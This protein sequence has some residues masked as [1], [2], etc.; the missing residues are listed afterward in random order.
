MQLIEHIEVGSG[1][2]ASITFSAIPDTFTDLLIFGS[3]RTTE[4]G[5]ID[6]L[7]VRPN[8]LTTNFSWRRLI[9]TG[10]AASSANGTSNDM[11]F[12]NTSGQTANTFGNFQLYIPN[13]ASSVA[14]SLSCDSVT[15]NNATAGYQAIYAGLWNSTDPITS[16]ELR[17]SL[18]QNFL[19]HSTASLYGILAGSDGIVAVS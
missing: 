17:S 12:L 9:G 15:E 19:E 18:S 6:G 4:G 1:G 3:I 5:T 13:Y 2:A 8:G 11:G 7:W 16:I 10:S 14:K